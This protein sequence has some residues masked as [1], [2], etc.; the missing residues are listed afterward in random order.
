MPK[1]ATPVTD[2]AVPTP[3]ADACSA[4]DGLLRAAAECV[5]HHER[6][7]RCLELGCSDDELAH[8]GELTVLTDAHLDAMTRT[9]EASANVAPEAKG[10]TW[11]H[12]ANTLWLAS[13]EY[14]RRSAGT[15]RLLRSGGKH[16]RERL[17][18]LAMEYELE[19]SALM[20]LKQAVAALRAI[21]PDAV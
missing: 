15:N 8:I 13:R 7:G 16:S 11:W 3:A 1:S 19:R 5:R 12:A 6:V 18:E 14:V 4:A 2:D 9:Y 17:S 20:A 10:Q 21:R